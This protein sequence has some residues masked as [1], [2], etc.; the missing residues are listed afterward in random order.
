MWQFVGEIEYECSK[1]SEKDSIPVEDFNCECIGGDERSMGA[2]EIYELS[3]PFECNECSNDI[4]LTFEV[5]EYPI[6]L[7]NFTIDKCSGAKALNEP[8]VEYVREIYSARD[9]FDLYESIPELVLALKSTPE[10]LSEL[11]P[12]QFE[13]VTA[14]IFRAKG[15]EVELTKRTRDGGKDVIAL[16]KDKLGFKTKYLIE[17]KHY[18]ENNKVGVDV[19][20]SLY[21]VKNSRSGGNVAIVVTTSTFTSGAR[22]FVENEATT[23]LDLSLADKNQLLEWLADYQES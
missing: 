14:E 22:D 17:C 13:E 2:E 8:D 19:I 10:L 15:F 3:Y 4:E 5:S 16:H 12:R 7:I 23:N 21:G 18:A 1:C 6:G 9:L 20:R 11:D